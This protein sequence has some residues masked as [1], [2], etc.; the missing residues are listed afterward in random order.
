MLGKNRKSEILH[1]AQIEGTIRVEDL[2]RRFGVAE[3]TIRRDLAQLSD[4]GQLERVHGGAVVSSGAGNLD[5]VQRRN[6]N[7]EGKA[8]IGRECAGSIPNGATVFINIGT[9]TEA[10][11]HELLAHKDLLVVTNSLNT[12]NILAVNPDI[13]IVVAGG[14]LRRTDGGLLGNL[15]TQVVDLFKFDHSIISCAGIDADLDLLDF[16]FQE[17]RATKSIIRQSKSTF[18]VADSSKMLRSAPGRIGNLAD[19]DILFTDAP[20]PDGMMQKARELGTSI[21]VAQP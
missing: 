18:V 16:D 9:T 6:R 1:I 14:S 21:N 13:E 15:T 20:L 5:Y 10:V 19:T 4:T 12:A 11:A 17:V 3:Q 2:A 8:R 7:T